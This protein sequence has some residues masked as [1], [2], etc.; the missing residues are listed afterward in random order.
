MDVGSLTQTIE[1]PQRWVDALTW[2][3]A[4]RLCYEIKDVDIAM[5]D[6]L[7]PIAAQQMASAFSEERDNSPF[8]M[9]PNV[10]MYTV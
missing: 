1:V 2:E 5:A 8:M 6:R 3:L 7:A 10:S 9:A 4:H